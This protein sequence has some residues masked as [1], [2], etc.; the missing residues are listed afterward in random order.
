MLINHNINNL[1]GGVSQQP[2]ET[3]YDNQV[4]EQINF[5]P[6]IAQGLRRRN[7]LESVA[8]L[9]DNIQ[10]DM[11]I[12]SYD[13]GD[14]LEEYIIRLD[15]TGL[16][17]YDKNGNKKTVSTIGTNPL[18]V[19]TVGNYH[20]D[21]QMLTVGDTTWVL[22][23]NKIVEML[24]DLTP[25]IGASN[26]AFYWLKRSYDNG[27][28]GGYTYYVTI[29]GVKFTGSGINSATVADSISDA[30]NQRYSNASNNPTVF[31]DYIR[32]IAIDSVI[33]IYIAK[34]YAPMFRLHTGTTNYFV[35]IRE[36]DTGNIVGLDVEDYLTS[37]GLINGRYE[38]YCTIGGVTNFYNI[39]NVAPTTIVVKY[40]SNASQA[41]S[42]TSPV[43][44]SMPLYKTNGTEDFTFTY[45]DSWGDQ[46]GMG[47]KG[48]VDKLSSIPS[49]MKGFTSSE[50]GTISIS[51]TDKDNFNNYYIMW[52]GSRWKET[53]AENIKYKLNKY[54]LPAKLVR[55]SNG[56]FVFGFLEDND[57]IDGFNNEWANRI[58]GDDDTVPI[59]SFIGQR[60]SNMFFYKNRLGFTSEENVVLSEVGNYY[61]FFAT[62]AMEVLDSDM[63]D[64]SVDS[65]TVTNIRNV[66]TT[67]GALTL[68]SDRGQFILGGG[69]TL[70]PTTVRAS[71][72][73]SYDC[74]NDLKPIAIDNE[75]LFFNK[76]GDSL[77][78][79][80][81]APA[82]IQDD[83]STASSISA[84]IPSYVPN[85]ITQ[86]VFSS[87][88]NLVIFKDSVDLNTL[89]L[90]K[91]HI[92]GQQ[93]VMSS[94]FKWTFTDDIK[95]ITILKDKLYLF[96]NSNK[97]SSINLEPKDINDLFLDYGVY[98]Y[99]SSVVLSSFNIETK[100]GTQVIREPFYPKN[101]KSN[102]FGKVDLD[103]IN[104]ERL[105]TNTVKTKHIPRKIFIGGNSEKINIGFSTEYSTGCQINAISL[106][107]RVKIRS[108]NI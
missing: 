45:G 64:V 102:I 42:N 100:Q 75:I 93:R 43:N 25:K 97:L 12:H 69:D 50:V 35:R 55:Q 104:S 41:V 30:I 80:I 54:T 19:W 81:F 1:S 15:S 23:K 72:T 11:Y 65:D 71:Q 95:A 70:T 79:S 39:V 49:D 36:I 52:T 68:W 85:T 6:T 59:P 40:Y 86:V 13:R 24:P 2:V 107:G 22:N 10:N 29:N 101:I 103:I 84:H 5:I 20:K 73:S 17:V 47:W 53:V 108:R 94:W 87:A 32:A 63:I 67:A 34:V 61:N 7:P 27:Q 76:I 4:E 16:F 83:K 92:Q 56:S 46:A 28:G 105:S 8:T 62:T 91:Y 58:C 31:P 78:T 74:A 48:T 9:A 14:G 26:K 60:L 99:K 38:L 89:W 96:M 3:R 88:Y 82:S 51:G 98:S 21:I 37:F 77:E 44:I 106:E 57:T 18:S 33:N 90:Y 66:N